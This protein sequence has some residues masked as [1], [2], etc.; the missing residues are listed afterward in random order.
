VESVQIM[1][2]SALKLALCC[3]C[4]LVASS[5][6]AVIVP[7]RNLNQLTEQADVV[8]IGSAA[9]VSDLGA[10]TVKTS[11]TRTRPGGKRRWYSSSMC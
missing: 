11:T 8:V 2:T 3:V 6:G 1:K 4:V 9:H 10:T 5:V 7:V